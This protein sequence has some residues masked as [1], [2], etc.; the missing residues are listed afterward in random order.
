MPVIE[1]RD[2]LDLKEFAEKC[3]IS[4]H[5]ARKWASARRI[6]TIKLGTRVVVPMSELDRLLEENFRPARRDVAV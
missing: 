4:L 2:L 1:S 6:G 5:T 3:K